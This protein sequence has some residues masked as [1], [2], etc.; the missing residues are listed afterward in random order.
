[1][2]TIADNILENFNPLSAQAERRG[3]ELFC[4]DK[5]DFN[6]LSAQAERRIY[7]RMTW[8]IG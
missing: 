5:N 1:M 6:P 7:L 2:E 4:A 8:G 3:G